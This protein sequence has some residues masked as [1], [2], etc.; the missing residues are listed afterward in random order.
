MNDIDKFIMHYGVKGMRWGQR[1]RRKGGS[2]ELSDEA[3]RAGEILKKGKTKSVKS[4]TNAEIREFT[5]RLQ[6]E[7]SFKNATPTPGRK[8]LNTVKDLLGVKN[9]MDQV[10]TF[11]ASPSGQAIS[12]GLKKRRGGAP[13][14]QS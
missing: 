10:A 13:A 8:V 9:T 11:S 6:L 2:V 5:Q 7:Q 3:R 1:R 4:L 14:T 12:A